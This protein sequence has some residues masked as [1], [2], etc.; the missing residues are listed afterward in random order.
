[1]NCYGL[2]LTEILNFNLDTNFAY[3][4]NKHTKTYHSLQH[5]LA[6]E[7]R[8]PICKQSWE[9]WVAPWHLTFHIK[10]PLFGDNKATTC[11]PVRHVATCLACKGYH[12][13]P[14]W[15]G[16][17]VP[18]YVIW[19]WRLGVREGRVTTMRRLALFTALS[20]TPAAITGLFLSRCYLRPGW[21]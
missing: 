5:S 12:G 4:N 9:S 11:A 3:Q 2:F 19:P 17:G 18:G 21:P 20:M 8:Q 16:G 13:F 14:W 7:M 10:I 6:S 15:G 1:M